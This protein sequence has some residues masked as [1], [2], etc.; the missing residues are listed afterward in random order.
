MSSIA[1]MT[2]SG[3]A[4]VSG[5]EFAHFRGL[6]DAM[7]WML[8]EAAFPGGGGWG[9]VGL[10]SCVQWPGWVV[11]DDNWRG[12]RDRARL[13]LRTDGTTA[14]VLHPAHG[15]HETALEV[16][17][18]S[19]LEMA[20]PP[21]ALA[22]RI[23][24]QSEVHAWIA[25]KDRRWAATLIDA[26]RRIGLFRDEP[27]TNGSYSGWAGVV[28]LLRSEQD[29]LVVLSRSNSDDF[30]GPEVAYWPGRVDRARRTEWYSDTPAGRWASAVAGL[31]RFTEDRCALLRIGRDNLRRPGFGTA[32]AWTWAQLGQAWQP[33]AV[34]AFAAQRAQVAAETA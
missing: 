20:S 34:E 19:V 11:G 7:A 18:N 2:A 4:R 26:G 9:D 12:F 27:S 22:T 15:E 8:L 5:R 10:R 17:L 28:E 13:Y 32:H 24:C 1:F 29:S 6:F 14:G 23:V 30:P 31:R 25:P 33:V 21:L 3:E 16:S